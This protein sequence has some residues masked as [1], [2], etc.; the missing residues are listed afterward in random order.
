MGKLASY[1]SKQPSSQL[2]KEGEHVVSLLDYL[3]CTS[4]DEVKQS[5]VV[6]LKDD[7]PEWINPIDVLGIHVGN[8]SGSLFHRLHLAGAMRFS[9]LSDKQLQSG[10]FVDCEGFA[11]EK[12][13]KGLVRMEDPERTATCERILDHLLFAIGAEPGTNA[14][15]ALDAAIA[16]KE[17]F[18]IDV[19][20]EPWETGD[21]YRISKF[22]RVGAVVK[23]DT[24]SLQA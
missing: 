7:L 23:A 17:Q 2:L 21:Q 9:E 12:T 1:E 3:E 13:K 5:K 14:L 20:C 11:C 15:E 24:D 10:K 4:F 6:G 18:V 19:V 16:N 8:A 22:R